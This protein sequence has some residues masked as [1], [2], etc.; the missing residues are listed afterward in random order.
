MDRYLFLFDHLTH[1]VEHM[2]SKAIIVG[3]NNWDKD[4]NFDWQYFEKET[5]NFDGFASK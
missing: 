5:E 1:F 2:C 3:P 4:E